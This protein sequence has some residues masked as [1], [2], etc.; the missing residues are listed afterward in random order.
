MKE[1]ISI[2]NTKDRDLDISIVLAYMDKINRDF[3]SG[4]V[5]IPELGTALIMWPKAMRHLGSALSF[6]FADTKEK[7]QDMIDN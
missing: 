4:K 6:S 7:G 3:A 5:S 2:S 1:L